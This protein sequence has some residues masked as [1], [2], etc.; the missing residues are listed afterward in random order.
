MIYSE[1]S[2]NINWILAPL[3]NRSHKSPEVFAIAFAN[4]TFIS[5]ILYF[6]IQEI[7]KRKDAVIKTIIEQN[8]I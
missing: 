6:N 8:I 3:G 1:L 5:S 4:L 2:F 7:G